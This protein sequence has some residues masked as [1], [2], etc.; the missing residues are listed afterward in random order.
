MNI[1]TQSR[2]SNAETGLRNKAMN[3]VGEGEELK[4][5]DFMNL[6]MT[7]MSHQ[8]PLS[9]MDSGAMMT[10]LAQL[11]SMEQL[12]NINGQLGDMNKT[13]QEISRFQALNFLDKDVMLELK[14]LELANGT[15]RPVY[16]SLDNDVSNVKLT[17]EELDGSPV[18]S[19]NLGLVTAGK[20]QYNWDGKNDEGVMMGDGNYKIRLMVTKADGSN[21]EIDL[22]RSGRIS[23]VE[24]RK[25]Q[26]WVKVNGTMMPLSKVSAINIQTQK[27]FGNATPL[28][29]MQDLEPKNIAKT[30]E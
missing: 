1:E 16:Y 21:S 26:P 12:Q 25:G 5:Q 14:N 27:L 4:K 23:Q 28:S 18:F 20:H 15:G 24:Y 10:Q 3:Q 19:D 30:I 11:G 8:D 17:I 6:F 13:Q 7:Q 22:F 2:I 9:P 29:I